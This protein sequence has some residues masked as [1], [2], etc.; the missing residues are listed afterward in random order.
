MDRRDLYSECNVVG[1]P[2]EAFTEECCKHCINPE[3][4]RSG[5][6]KTKFDQRVGS[7][8]ERMF[9]NVPRMDPNDPRFEKITAQKFMII[10][11]TLTLQSAWVD[12]RELDQPA[13]PRAPEP[14]PIV[15]QAQP[16][17]APEPV[18]VAAPEPAAPQLAPAPPPAPIEPGR[19]PQHLAFTNAPLQQGQMLPGAPAQKP[20]SSWDAPVPTP[21]TDT[22]GV[23]VVKS[24][25][26]V[27]LG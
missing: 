9:Q 10:N 21:T 26:R 13:P 4:T 14:A 7:W 25:A 16:A 11:P 8:Y 12:P 6:G 3:C 18:V 24:G 17:P 1:A 20:A 27:K 19:L 22:E 2:L 5:F 15:V 23:K